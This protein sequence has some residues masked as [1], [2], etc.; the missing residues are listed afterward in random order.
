[1]RHLRR[2]PDFPPAAGR[3][4]SLAHTMVERDRLA[5]RV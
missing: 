2:M 3:S 4:C 1:V 5:K